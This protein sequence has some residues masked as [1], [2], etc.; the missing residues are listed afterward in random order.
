ME[1]VICFFNNIIELNDMAVFLSLRLY[2]EVF[3]N[4]VRDLNLII[5]QHLCSFLEQLNGMNY[6]HNRRTKWNVFLCWQNKSY[7][8]RPFLYDLL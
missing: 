4:Y 5:A 6:G 1:E 8:W 3:Q 2:K 7:R